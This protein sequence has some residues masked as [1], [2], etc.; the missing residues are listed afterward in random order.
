MALPKPELVTFLLSQMPPQSA[1][2]ACRFFGGW[3]LLA[4]GR[5]FAIMMKGTLYFRVNGTLQTEM[6]RLGCRPFT[7][8]TSRKLVTVPRYMSAPDGCLDDTELL[9]AWVT[10]IIAAPNS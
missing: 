4:A 7:Y 10:R 1:V 3:Q 5:Q 6:E 2:T 9:Q 8:A